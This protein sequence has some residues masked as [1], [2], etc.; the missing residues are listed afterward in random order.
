MHDTL[1]TGLLI[2]T[3]SLLSSCGGG[4][5]KTGAVAPRAA[6]IHVPRLLGLSG[7][8]ALRALKA[9]GLCAKSFE[10]VAATPGVADASVRVILSSRVIGQKP[11]AG[12]L[13][14]H[15]GFV[16]IRVTPPAISP[17]AD[18]TEVRWAAA[19]AKGCPMTSFSA[20]ARAIEIP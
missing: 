17:P 7:I 12:H 11:G 14:P 2:G 8:G 15:L 1:R 10:S 5:D 18:I 19:T 9:K 6:N 3:V 4:A 20:S 16:E 13:L